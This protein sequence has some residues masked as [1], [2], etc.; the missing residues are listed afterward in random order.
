[1]IAASRG[2]RIVRQA[3][4]G[5]LDEGGHIIVPPVVLTQTLRGGTQDAAI[6]QVL[7]QTFLSFV[8]PRLA[9]RAGELLGLA[10]LDDAAD[11]QIMAEAVRNAPC[12]LLTSDP[13]DMRA[14][15]AGRTNIRILAI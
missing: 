2:N 7:R 8:G 9:R 10:G 5:A 6:H 4:Q 15:A 1:M 12:I 3:I 13:D 11:A 14:L